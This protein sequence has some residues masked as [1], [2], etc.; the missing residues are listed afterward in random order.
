M[1]SKSIVVICICVCVMVGTI[2]FFGM[3]TA[4]INRKAAVEQAEIE[5]EREKAVQAEK[6]ERTEE[7]SQFWQKVVP[8]GNDEAEENK[9]GV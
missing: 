5:R 8:W 6:T 3:R 2:G 9:S 4:E 7:R 1:S